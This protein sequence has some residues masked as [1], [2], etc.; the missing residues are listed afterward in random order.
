MEHTKTIKGIYLAQE[1][2]EKSL[3]TTITFQTLS[4]LLLSMLMLVL[5]FLNKVWKKQK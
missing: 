4:I 2:L 3:R 5:R 1:H